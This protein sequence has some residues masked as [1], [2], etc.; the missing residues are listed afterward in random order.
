MGGQRKRKGGRVTP[1][2]KSHR[3][4]TAER[5]GLEDIFAGILRSAST[6]LSDDISPLVVEMWA[7]Q[8]WSVWAG[9]ELIRM[10]AVEVFAGGMIDYAARRATPAG[11]MVLRALSAVAPDPYG[12]RARLHA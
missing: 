5:T 9:S 1:K 6:D 4:S 10:D 7:S 2:G 12:S 8:M 11:L 3:L